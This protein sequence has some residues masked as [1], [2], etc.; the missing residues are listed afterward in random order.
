MSCVIKVLDMEREVVSIQ[1]QEHTI[2]GIN[3]TC[4]CNLQTMNGNQQIC[5]CSV[6]SFSTVRIEV[7]LTTCT[8]QL[9]S[10]SSTHLRGA[11]VGVAS[12]WGGGV[13]GDNGEGGHALREGGGP[14]HI[15]RRADKC[16][17]YEDSAV[18]CLERQY[19]DSTGL[20]VNCTCRHTLLRVYTYK[21]MHVYTY[22]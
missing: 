21:C 16:T 12:E 15:V 11:V 22:M 3:A 5:H 4:T 20:A 13:Q 10:H 2:T 8:S 18:K 1:D 7:S 17:R 9:S 14:S 6:H 19:E